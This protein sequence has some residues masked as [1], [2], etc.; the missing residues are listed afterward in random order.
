MKYEQ[1]K[2][3]LKDKVENLYLLFGEDLFLLD[4]SIKLIKQFSNI[5]MPE[6]NISSY[7]EGEIDLGAICK[8]LETMPAFSNKKLVYL[9]F[10]TKNS[11]IVNEKKL[12]EYLENPNSS[13]I[14]VINI[15][16]MPKP[17][18]I[19]WR[20]FTE[21][22]CNKLSTEL[23]SKFIV[24]NI[25][26]NKKQITVDALNTLIDY[27]LGDLQ[28]ISSEIV[29]ICNYVGE[30]EQIS[31]ADINYNVKKSLEYQIFELTEGLGKKDF[32]KTFEILDDIKLGGKPKSKDAQSG[33][34]A[35]R[36]VFALIYNHFRRLFFV[37]LNSYS[38][39]EYAKYLKVQEYAVTKIMN[40][41]KMFTS[42]KLKEI[43]DLCADFDFKIKQ[44]QIQEWNAIE[45]I[46]LSILN[47]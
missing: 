30:K 8:E 10:S 16:V 11:K 33:S 27:T 32:K 6:I 3:S 42:K 29:K 26:Q 39:G 12:N 23:V 13:S 17:E 38:K 5:E 44:S 45:I 22:D 40:Q 9:D 35:V 47:Q 2:A 31:L 18:K 34:N 25:K 21:V 20:N 15:G 4:N 36:G 41:V 28:V 37:S 19:D 1:L 7:S 14:L 43:I 46:C 24:A